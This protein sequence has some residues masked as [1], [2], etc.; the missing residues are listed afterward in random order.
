MFQCPDLDTCRPHHVSRSLQQRDQ[1]CSFV[2]QA[3]TLHALRRVILGHDPPGLTA[4]QKVMQARNTCG[5]IVMT[6]CV[7]LVPVFCTVKAIGQGG[8]TDVVPALRVFALA[9]SSCSPHLTTEVKWKSAAWLWPRYR[10]D[11]SA[12][13]QFSSGINFKH[14]E[15]WSAF[16]VDAVLCC[17]CHLLLRR[18]RISHVGSGSAPS[19]R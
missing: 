17:T 4:L 3:A 1:G 7:D 11:E 5:C 14:F 16:S 2:E 12:L 6:M 10:C 18:T 8:C 9:D 13:S 19:A 15:L